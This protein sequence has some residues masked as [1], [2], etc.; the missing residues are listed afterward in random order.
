M[1]CSHLI[2]HLFYECRRESQHTRKQLW[3]TWTTRKCVTH[4]CA[5]A[6]ATATATDAAD[7]ADAAAATATATSI[8][9]SAIMSY[10]NDT[11]SPPLS[12]S[13]C[14]L[15]LLKSLTD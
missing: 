4:A 14:A 12:R 11:Q 10:I 9:T 7:A 8:S 6:A 5:A 15:M 3:I 13:H 1:S 2:Y